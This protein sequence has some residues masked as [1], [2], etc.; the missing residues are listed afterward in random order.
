MFTKYIKI[1]IIAVFVLTVLIGTWDGALAQG[2]VPEEGKEL[3]SYNLDA[4]VVLAVK[5]ANWILGIVGSLALLFFIYGGF[6]FI[7]S[8]GKAETISKG[9]L[10]LTNSII[11][12]IIV[13]ASY[14]IIQFTLT[15]LGVEGIRGGNWAEIGSGWFK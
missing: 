4:L 12:L 14:L 6:T 2:I 3:G 13:F 8:G 10:I 1:I 9:K 15:A 11:G 5:I 7:L